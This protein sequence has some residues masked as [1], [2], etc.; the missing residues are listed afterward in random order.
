MSINLEAASLDADAIAPI[1]FR[2]CLNF[3]GRKWRRV[4]NSIADESNSRR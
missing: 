4:K 2:A 1:T 3:A